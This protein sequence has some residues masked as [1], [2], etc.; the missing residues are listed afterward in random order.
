MLNCSVKKKQK[1]GL[2]VT[3]NEEGYQTLKKD[4][5]VVKNKIQ[6]LELV[7]NHLEPAYQ[8]LQPFYEP[9]IDISIIETKGESFY[10][11]KIFVVPADKA[12]KR[13]ISFVIG[14]IEN[15]KDINDERLLDDTKKL[16]REQLTKFYPSYFE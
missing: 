1:M 12:M 8:Q 2:L 10:S 15:Y 4:R 11:G 13:R 5:E 6:E 16:A 14:P 3:L 7:L 9:K